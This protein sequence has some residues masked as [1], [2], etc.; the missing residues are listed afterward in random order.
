MEN[1]PQVIHSFYSHQMRRSN[2][3]LTSVVQ[4]QDKQMGYRSSYNKVT[5]SIEVETINSDFKGKLSCMVIG[6]KKNSAL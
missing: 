2:E 6:K 1:P 3:S 5:K 4:G